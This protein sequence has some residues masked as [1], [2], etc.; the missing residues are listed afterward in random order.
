MSDLSP[1]VI[2]KVIRVVDAYIALKKAI[3]SIKTDE[4]E[5]ALYTFLSNVKGE[6]KQ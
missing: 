1:V 3:D 2:V 4:E 6:M 5:V